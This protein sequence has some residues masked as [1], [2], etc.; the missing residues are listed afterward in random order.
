[1]LFSKRSSACRLSSLPFHI[2]FCILYTDRLL[3][4]RLAG[5]AVVLS[6]YQHPQIFE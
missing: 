2:L 6:F 1:M 4:Y 3:P 5:I